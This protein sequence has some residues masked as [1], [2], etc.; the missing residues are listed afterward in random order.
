MKILQIVRQFRPSTGGLENAVEGLSHAV[1]EAGHEVNIVTLRK[2][3]STGEL[4]P[5]CSIE[6]GLNISRISSWGSRRYSIAPG[7]LKHIDSHDVLHEIGR[8]HV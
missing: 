6:K 3:F 1:Q 5:M 2:I 4:A 8:A 7:V